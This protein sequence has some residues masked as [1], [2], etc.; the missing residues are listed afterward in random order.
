MAGSVFMSK[1]HEMSS[2]GPPLSAVADRVVMNMLSFE[3]LQS[4]S[5]QW[6]LLIGGNFGLPW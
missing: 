1:A 5:A 4:S 6:Q 2:L 3:G